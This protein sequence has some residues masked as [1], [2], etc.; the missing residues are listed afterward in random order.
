MK[1]AVEK[2][3]LVHK[4]FIFGK[5]SGASFCHKCKDNKTVHL[6]LDE[7]LRERVP[8]IWK[9]LH[10]SSLNEIL[11]DSEN[12]HAKVNCLYKTISLVENPKFTDYRLVKGAEEIEI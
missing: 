4:I 7:F 8:R 12:P 10:Q 11:Y 2:G 3:L 5:S 6:D 1:L 9:K